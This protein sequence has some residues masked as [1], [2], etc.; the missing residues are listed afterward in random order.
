MGGGFQAYVVG[1]ALKGCAFSK[2]FHFAESF[3]VLERVVVLEGTVCNLLCI[4]AA[5]GS[6]VDVFQEDPVHGGLDGDSGSIGIHH[7]VVSA[8]LGKGC[9]A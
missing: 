5:I 7:Q 6:K 3:P 1:V 8:R 9:N 4:Q 2:D